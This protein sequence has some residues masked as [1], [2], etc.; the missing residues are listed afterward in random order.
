M[1]GKGCSEIDR[2]N[3]DVVQA[4]GRFGV[5]II[6]YNMT[7]VP[8]LGAPNVVEFMRSLDSVYVTISRIL[9]QAHREGLIGVGEA[10]KVVTLPAEKRTGGDHEEG[11]TSPKRAKR[12]KQ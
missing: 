11:P 1:K 7:K 12:N 10:R 4:V 8:Y 9:N 2:C 5:L 6:D 3:A